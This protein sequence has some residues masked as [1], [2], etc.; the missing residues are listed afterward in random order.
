MQSIKSKSLNVCT[1][2]FVS[3]FVLIITS[4][5]KEVTVAP[6]SPNLQAGKS[7]ARATSVT[8]NEKIKLNLVVWVPCA[9]G[10]AGENISLS[11]YLHSLSSTT[12]N[13]KKVRGKYHFQPQ[14]I[15]G[16]GSITGDKYQAAGVTEGQFNGSLVN[17]QY[18]ESFVN[19]FNIIGQGTGN[20]FMLHENFHITVN[21]NGVVTTT[22]DNIKDYCK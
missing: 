7:Q 21:A 4:C 18:Q 8:T 9:N 10:G 14:G 2:F 19:N 17:D 11:G 16:V 5:K 12:I 3:T 20:N 13:G 1:L 6:A 22:I 15:V